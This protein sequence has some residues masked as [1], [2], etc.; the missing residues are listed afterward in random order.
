[1]DLD[2][3]S[4]PRQWFNWVRRL[5]SFS[6][7]YRSQ[8]VG[9]RVAEPLGSNIKA[10]LDR[11]TKAAWGTR[12]EIARAPLVLAPRSFQGLDSTSMIAEM[13]RHTRNVAPRFNAPMMTPRITVEPLCTAAGQF[14]EEDGWV[15]ITVSS[16]F[17]NDLPAAR[18]ILCHELCH[19]V[20]NASGIREQSR[21]ENERLTDAAMFVL[22]LG[23]IFLAGY[24]RAP[25]REYRTGHRLGYLSDEEYH[26]AAA[27][28]QQLRSSP[29]QFA[30]TEQEIETRLRAVVHDPAKR[31]NLVAGYRR[32][33][34]LKTPNEIAQRII[35]DIAK[36]NR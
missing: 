9:R 24:R 4:K 20:L 10:K 2:A 1:L 27:Y 26:Y 36:D 29:D 25:K 15:K 28:V 16:T 11:L 8:M 23:D 6:G 13:L 22:G 5:F 17:F 3:N 32:K 30:S 7:G 19:Y 35:D 33:F 14:V 31:A 18:S 34:P 12:E 21:D